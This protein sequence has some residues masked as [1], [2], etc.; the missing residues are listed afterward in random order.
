MGGGVEVDGGTA[1]VGTAG[2]GGGLTA[3]GVPRMVA[4]L[5]IAV[6]VAGQEPGA[7]ATSRS[8]PAAKHISAKRLPA[9]TLTS[10]SARPHRSQSGPISGSPGM[11]TPP[12]LRKCETARQNRGLLAGDLLER[13]FVALLWC[14]G[15]WM[16]HGTRRRADSTTVGGAGYGKGAVCLL[17]REDRLDGWTD[18]NIRADAVERSSMMVLCWVTG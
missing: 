8:A 5:A 15:R 14:L 16:R 4:T 13:R 12:T 7:V 6:G 17:G 1:G 11:A 9:K 18:G 2:G 10:P 3:T